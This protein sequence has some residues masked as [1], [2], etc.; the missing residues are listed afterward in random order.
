MAVLKSRPEIR[1]TTKML[2]RLKG[3]RVSA[4]DA[5]RALFIENVAKN[6]PSPQLTAKTQ[7]MIEEVR[8]A[9][10]ASFLDKFRRIS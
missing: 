8:T 5:R 9:R 4:I 3:V 6:L 1:N 7:T 10:D 2:H